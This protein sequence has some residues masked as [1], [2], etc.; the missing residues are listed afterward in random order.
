MKLDI[1][2]AL[3]QMASQAQGEICMLCANFEPGNGNGCSLKQQLK[4]DIGLGYQD[5]R[6][7]FNPWQA[8]V[9]NVGLKIIQDICCDAFND[10]LGYPDSHP[11]RG[12]WQCWGC[13]YYLSAQDSVDCR[14][15][16]LPLE[17]RMCPV[18]HNNDTMYAV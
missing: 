14:E 7:L 3:E 2:G 15:Q 6:L 17:Q 8:A 13:G 9:D 4:A 1:N 11:K 12:G 18:C 5:G 10:E 16:S